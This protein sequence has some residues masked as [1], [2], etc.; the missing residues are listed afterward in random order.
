MSIPVD[1]LAQ[2]YIYMELMTCITLEIGTSYC[3]AEISRYTIGRF[4]ET[5]RVSA[6]L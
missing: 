4:S 5:I 1:F 6:C 2:K 3:Y